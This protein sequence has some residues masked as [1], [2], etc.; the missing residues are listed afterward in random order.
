M[1]E[2]FALALEARGSVWH[3]SFSLGCADLAAKVR[4]ARF[5]K[6]ALF[7]FRCTVYF[8]QDGLRLKLRE[9]LGIGEGGGGGGKTY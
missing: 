7:A 2:F 4:F 3:N 1:K 9:F 5:T 6:L 8:C